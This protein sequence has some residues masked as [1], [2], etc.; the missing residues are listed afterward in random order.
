[1]PTRA[2]LHRR[3]VRAGSWLTKQPGKSKILDPRPDANRHII[4]TRPM[5]DMWSGF[6][7]GLKALMWIA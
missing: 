5:S 6:V 3:A 2:T 1:M 7:H 4:A